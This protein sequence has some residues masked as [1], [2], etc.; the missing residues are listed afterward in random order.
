MASLSIPSKPDQKEKD[1]YFYGLAGRPRLVA[2][3]STNPW[4]EPQ[5]MGWEVPVKTSKV[6][7]K[8]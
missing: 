5:H 4:T 6:Y 2:R 8:L 3:T 7:Q 1:G